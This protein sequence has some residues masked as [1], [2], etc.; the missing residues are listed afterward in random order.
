MI[1]RK[2][3]V[4]NIVKVLIFIL[5]S[6]SLCGCFNY[7]DVNRVAFVT[8]I[9]FDVDKDKNI[10]IYLEAFKPFR[11]ASSA[12][13]K[14]QRLLFKGIGKTIFEASRNINLKSSFIINYTQNRALIFTKNAAEFGIDKY[15]DLLERDQEFL[16][17]PYLYIYTGE[18]E[19]LMNLKIEAEEYIGIFLN[20][21]IQNVG[22]SSRAVNITLAEYLLKRTLPSKTTVLTTIDIDHEGLS[23]VIQINGG[24]IIKDDKLVEIMSRDQGQAYNFL[25]NTV[26]RGTLEIT[27]PDEPDNYITLEILKSKTKSKIEFEGERIKLKK[28]IKIKVSIGE[29]QGELKVDSE[30]LSKIKENSEYNIAKYSKMV[31]E[32]FKNKNIDIFEVKQELSRKYPKIEIPDNY[33]YLTD[34][35]INVEVFV[36]GS[37]SILNSL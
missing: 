1:N 22:V 27:N 19:E 7:R 10:I 34:I 20:D 25:N 24:A 32:G 17:R 31:F 5:L 18:P 6:S 14:G 36:E 8:A 21:L 3:I 13:E 9:L 2:L 12:S 11:S 16:V 15:I 28:D 35:D 23:K 26:K 30:K 37:N 29:V 33:M 4:K